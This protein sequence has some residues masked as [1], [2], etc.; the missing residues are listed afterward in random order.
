M[1]LL[2]LIRLEELVGALK[3]VGIN[4]TFEEFRYWKNLT[5][6]EL[7]PPKYTEPI[8]RGLRK[9]HFYI[10][11][12]NG[13]TLLVGCRMNLFESKPIVDVE[14][15]GSDYRTIKIELSR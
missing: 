14:I 3:A 1:K 12:E 2:H 4:V 5:F 13:E 15:T 6:G 7:K 10:K 11:D 9:F 8:R